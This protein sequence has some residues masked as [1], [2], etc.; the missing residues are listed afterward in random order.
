[1][2]AATGND[3]LRELTYTERRRGFSLDY[4][5]QAEQQG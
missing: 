5:T 3:H 4:F 1:V 2:L